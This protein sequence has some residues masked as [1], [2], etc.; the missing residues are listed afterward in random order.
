MLNV[1]DLSA[2][3]GAIPVLH[4][5]SMT[6]ASGESLGILGHNGMGKTTF[7]RCLIG[8]LAPSGGHVTLDG[9]DVTRMAPHGRARLGMA[10][11]PQG[12]EIFA[13]LSVRDNLRMGL[14]KTGLTTPDQLDAL[15]VDFR[16]SCLCST[17]WAARSRVASSSSSHSPALWPA[18][19]A[20]SCSTSQPKASSLR[21][22]KR[23]H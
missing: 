6:I 21:S 4:G 14:V 13:T 16:A 23:S 9:L 17:E 15:L 12:R 22:S 19:R 1:S 5:I 11:V 20:S 2:G 7:L 8:A 10:Y 18:S 3:Y